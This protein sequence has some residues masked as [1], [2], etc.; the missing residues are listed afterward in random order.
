MV[1]PDGQEDFRAWSRAFN[2]SGAV[3]TEVVASSL[4]YRRTARNV[5]RSGYDHYQINFALFGQCRIRVG[6]QSM[7]LRRGEIGI[8]DCLCASDFEVHATHGRLAHTL[9]LFVPRAAL[10]PLLASPDAARC[11]RMRPGTSAVRLLKSHLVRLLRQA[12]TMTAAQRDSAA[13][14]LIGLVAEALNAPC[15]GA[16]KPT[17]RASSAASIKCHIER[18]LH[19]PA[20]SVKALATHFGT[21]RA[22][23]YRLF[24]T[25]G[26]L[27]N[28]I[29]QR[30][31]LYAFS[32]LLSV[33]RTPRRILDLALDCRFASDA[34]FNRA[35]RR[36]F[37][38]PPGEA[39]DLARMARN[40]LDPA[41]P[42]SEWS[43]TVHWIQALGMRR[44]EGIQD[45][46]ASVLRREP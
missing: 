29:Q 44:A 43:K 36:E 35:F 18:H 2:L 46:A 5:A 9:T 4:H 12:Y 19:S 20:L 23:L 40:R 6:Q 14:T 39:R 10:A 3:L 38:L 30:R 1:A 26:G 34:T 25:E 15:E 28:Y 31:L 13:P 21:S 22:S 42:Q 24:D 16:A 8:L 45:A 33:E 11:A 27:R 41:P 7:L 32:W 37:G 17:P